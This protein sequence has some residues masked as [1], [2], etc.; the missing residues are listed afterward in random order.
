MEPMQHHYEMLGPFHRHQDS[1][2]RLFSISMD[3]LSMG[4]TL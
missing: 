2:A 1:E 3:P 4:V